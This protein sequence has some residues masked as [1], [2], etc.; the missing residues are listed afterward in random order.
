MLRPYCIFLFILSIWVYGCHSDAIESVNRSL[1]AS[2]CMFFNRL[3]LESEKATLR[4][5][6]FQSH[7]IYS[8]IW[9]KLDSTSDTWLHSLLLFG[10]RE[11]EL[12][13]SFAD[14]SGSGFSRIIQ[15]E[16][17]IP[18]EQQESCISQLLLLNSWTLR[19]KRMLFFMAGIHFIFSFTWS[20]MTLVKTSQLR[21]W[22]SC[23]K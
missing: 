18:L 12:I 4:T 9:C 23:T 22:Q 5:E 15:N 8:K 2:V 6:A 19:C 14:K 1:P 11:S 20:Q 21:G 13:R 10:L 7:A 17:S 16:I 3:L